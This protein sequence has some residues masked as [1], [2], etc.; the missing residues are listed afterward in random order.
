V[1][2]LFISSRGCP[3]TKWFYSETH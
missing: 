3:H 2:Y 1:G